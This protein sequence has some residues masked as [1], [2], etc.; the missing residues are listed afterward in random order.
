MRK[1][2]EIIS[3]GPD[4]KRYGPYPW[5]GRQKLS[6]HYYVSWIYGKPA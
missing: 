3:D 4:I 5:S 2:T 1:Y 6:F